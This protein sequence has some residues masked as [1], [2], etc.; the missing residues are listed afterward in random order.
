MFVDIS[1][2]Y[3]IYNF[4]Q[5]GQRYYIAEVPGCYNLPPEFSAKTESINT[6]GKCVRVYSDTECK[7]E[8]K[9]FYPES[10]PYADLGEWNHKIK[11]WESCTL[12]HQAKLKFAQVK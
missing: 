3:F 2:F 1:V 12:T 10:S 11:S 4:Q 6:N 8:A 7:G 9:D 5:K